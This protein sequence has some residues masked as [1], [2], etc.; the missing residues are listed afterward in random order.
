MKVQALA[1][2]AAMTLCGAAIGDTVELI[3]G[4][5]L[6]G[7]VGTIA[8]GKMKFASTALGDLEI[9]MAKVKSISTDAPATIRTKSAGTTTDKI[10]A[11]DVNQ[12]TTAGGQTVGAA[13]LKDVNPPAQEWTGSVVGN[14]TLARGNTNRYTTGINAIASLRR[15]DEKNNDR[16]TLGGGYNY[17]ESGGGP[18]GGPKTVDTD[19]WNAGAKYD[20]FWNEKWYGYAG[21]RVEHD[22][23]AFL[24]YRIS[25]GV[26]V[27]YQWWERP[28]SHFNTE[29]G[30]SFIHENFDPGDTN[31]NVAVRLAYH[32]DR[33]LSENMT[34]FHNLE[35]LPAIDDPGDY[36][37]NTDLGVR[38]DVWKD[39]F[40]EAKVEWKRDST[41]ADN[42]LKNQLNYLLGLGWK[43]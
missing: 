20:R 42:T 4:D 36:L 3:N 31:N 29:A 43:F 10:T 13:D 14:F 19:N 26:G 28:D 12:I 21:V 18:P 15:D 22:R 6:T 41:P 30:F 8:G 17:G 24:H 40:V 2:A 37:L 39:L 9:D 35:Y 5:K 25:P 34:L 32:Y 1:L 33:D 38:A 16:F 11:G 27:G 7:T 23:V